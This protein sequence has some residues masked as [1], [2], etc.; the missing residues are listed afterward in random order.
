[1]NMND[2]LV[3][4]AVFQLFMLGTVVS[5]PQFLNA[6]YILIVPVR[7]GISVAVMVKLVA[8]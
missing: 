7:S 2:M 8:P 1:M 3:T 4:A 5:V 6:W